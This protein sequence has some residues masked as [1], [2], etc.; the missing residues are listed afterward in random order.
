LDFAATTGFGGTI[1]EFQIMIDLLNSSGTSL[2]T[3]EQK[4]LLTFSSRQLYGNPYYLT[5]ALHF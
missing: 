4:G 5:S 3:N 1:G 2:L